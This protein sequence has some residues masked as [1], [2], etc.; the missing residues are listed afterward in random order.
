MLRAVCPVG[1]LQ[2][3]PVATVRADDAPHRSGII[4]FPNHE[5]QLYQVMVM[6]MTMVTVTVLV[7]A[8]G[9]GA[10]CCH[11]SLTCRRAAS[12][13][14]ADDIVLCQC[15]RHAMKCAGGGAK[16]SRRH[17]TCCRSSDALVAVGTDAVGTDAVGTDA[18]DTDVAASPV[19]PPFFCP[20]LTLSV[21]ALGPLVYMTRSTK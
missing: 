19:L 16:I 8:A 15:P 10:D 18:V 5:E 6:A 1:V 17:H 20:P 7:K 12:R 13:L 2:P 21:I 11:F 14:N 9:L 4:L 3:V